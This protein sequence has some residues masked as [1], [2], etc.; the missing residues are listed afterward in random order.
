MAGTGS[1]DMNLWR[2]GFE[3][4]REDQTGPGARKGIPVDPY[5]PYSPS[6]VQ[7]GWSTQLPR[8]GPLRESSGDRIQK[9]VW[10]GG[11]GYFRENISRVR[12]ESKAKIS[13][14]ETRAPTHSPEGRNRG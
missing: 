12:T 8:A 7:K 1:L 14:C 4:G 5:P 9:S 2:G 10:N 6:E 13:L 11:T 3:Q